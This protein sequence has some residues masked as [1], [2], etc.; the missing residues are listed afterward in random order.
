MPMQGGSLYYFYGDLWY[1]PVGTQTLWPTAWE[2]DTLTA[3]LSGR[4][5]KFGSYKI[6][7][8]YDTKDTQIL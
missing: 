4:G 7:K 6:N 3:K 8:P 1:D 5:S 2:A